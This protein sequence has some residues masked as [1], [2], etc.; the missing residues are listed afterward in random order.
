MTGGRC[1]N[2]DPRSSCPMCGDGQ[3][4]DYAK[5]SAP[6][7]IKLR[8]FHSALRHKDAENVRKYGADLVLA[9]GAAVALFAE[10]A[11]EMTNLSLP[12]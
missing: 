3:S 10:K 11:E 4:Y 9:I 5:Y 12:E 7:Q 6:L 8:D 2:H 1:L